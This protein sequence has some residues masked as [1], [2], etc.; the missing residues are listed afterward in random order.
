MNGIVPDDPKKPYD[1]LEII[2]LVVDEGDFMEVMPRYAT[3]IIC[4]FGRLDGQPVGI[5]ANQPKI[6]AG[7]LC[8]DSSL[9]GARP[10][11][12]RTLTSSRLAS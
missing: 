1:M 12:E 4:G 10:T 7:V 5:V 2:R 8:I 3:N 9:K 11:P 6:N